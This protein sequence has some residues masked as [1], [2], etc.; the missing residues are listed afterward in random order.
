M[1]KVIEA[2]AKT[3]EVKEGWMKKATNMVKKNWKKILIGTG[4]TVA[5]I[6]LAALVV[7]KDDEDSKDDSE[8][9][10]NPLNDT[11]DELGSSIE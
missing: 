9:E 7:N 10:I 1:E 3:T 11:T 4:V 5:G 2:E 8:T 6:L